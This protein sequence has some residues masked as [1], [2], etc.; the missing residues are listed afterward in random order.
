M[1]VIVAGSRTFNDFSLVEKNL[2]KADI[3]IISETDRWADK[4]WEEFAAK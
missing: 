3:K 2:H 4:L 1:K